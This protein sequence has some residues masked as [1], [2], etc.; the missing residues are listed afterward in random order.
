MK[1]KLFDDHIKK[2]FEG[3]RPAVPDHIWDKIKADKRTKKPLPFWWSFLMDN[4]IAAI[5]CI[6]L[7]TS[8]V[9]YFITKKDAGTNSAA[10]QKE[11]VKNTSN[12]A[13]NTVIN[14]ENNNTTD[15]NRVSIINNGSNKK[16]NETILSTG[17]NT[18]LNS[19]SSLSKT[20]TKITNSSVAAYKNENITGHQYLQINSAAY[21]N[22]LFTG[23]TF[24]HAVFVQPA[25]LKNK[26]IPCPQIEKDAAANKTYI[27]VYAGPDYIFK[28]FADTSN[29][30]YLEQRRATNNLKFAYSAGVR[31][32]RVFKNGVSLRA[33]INYSQVNEQF[34]YSKGN[35]IRNVFV[36]NNAG[37]TTGSFTETGT[38]YQRS[39]NKYRTLDVPLVAGYE[40]GNGKVHANIYAGAM[41]NIRSRQTGYVLDQ[42]GNAVNISDKQNSSAYSYRTN[43]GVSFTGGVSLYYRINDN[44][45]VM[46]EPYIRYA[47]SPV[48]KPEITFKEKYHTAGIRMGVRMDL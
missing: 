40:L 15:S 6:L 2:Q 37:D 33:G 12:P 11:L 20:I 28:S 36:T 24:A 32:T 41:I 42:S 43:A 5:I 13:S 34:K 47:L 46:A 45:Q 14:T 48:T 30:A 39:T 31:Y 18:F 4:K 19:Y 9:I 29:S 8:A 23:K 1:N 3:Y 25:L 16:D 35:V 44:V 22:I 26:N 38:Q 27:E 17:S 10:A 7:C 21:E